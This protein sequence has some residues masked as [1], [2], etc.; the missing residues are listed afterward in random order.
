MMP[1]IQ[2]K[3][4]VTLDE[5]LNGVEQLNTPDLEFF[6]SQV[7]VLQ[8]R[9]RAPCLPRDEAEL[10]QKINQGLPADVWQRFDELNEK[11]RAETLTSE[12]HEELLELID[13]I[14]QWDARRVEYLAALAQLRNM[15]IRSLM[16]QLGIHRPAYV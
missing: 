9:R 6:V 8:A 16:N 4:E 12:E 10:L 11:R 3:S 5:L 13:E 7:L 2:V 1:T 14:E 15:S